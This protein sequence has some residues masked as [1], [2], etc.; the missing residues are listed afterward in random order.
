MFFTE[1]TCNSL[2]NKYIVLALLFN[3][4][5]MNKFV[6]ASPTSEAI[7]RRRFQKFKNTVSAILIIGAMVWCISAVGQSDFE[8]YQMECQAGLR[9]CGQ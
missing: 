3:T 5:S 6:R 1:K 4:A 9:T 2:Q 8:T 7:K